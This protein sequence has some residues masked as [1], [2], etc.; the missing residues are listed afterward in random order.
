[1]IAGQYQ[2]TY[3]STATGPTPVQVRFEEGP[4]DAVDDTTVSAP[5]A[6][7]TAPAPVPESDVFDAGTDERPILL[8]LLTIAG[9]ALVAVRAVR[10]RAR[11]RDTRAAAPVIDLRDPP[12]VS[13]RAKADMPNPHYHRESA[14][15]CPACGGDV[16]EGDWWDDPP[17]VGGTII[18]TLLRCRRDCGWEAEVL[19]AED[20]RR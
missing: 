11:A 8:A 20:P 7:S 3:E 9:L 4:E 19:D 15:K 16:E 2:L 12:E 10:R 1:L 6:P 18:G 13:T 14:T 17:A 5:S